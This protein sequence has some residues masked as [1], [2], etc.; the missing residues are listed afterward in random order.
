MDGLVVVDKPSG[1]S[2]HTAVQRMRRMANTRRIGHLGTL[3]PLASGVLPLV[4]GRATRL[5]KFFLG[6]ERSYE[7]TVRCGFS[8]TTYDR[9]GDPT[10]P[11][12]SVSLLARGLEEILHSFRG[13][14]SQCPPPF[15]AKKVGGERAYKLARANQP[16]QLQP[17]QV[18]IH[19][20]DLIDVA[21]DTFTV[22]IRC[23]SG[24]Y[25]R[26]LAHDIGQLLGCGAHVDSLRRIT[27]GELSIAD[28]R[29]LEELDYLAGRDRLEEALVEAAHLLPEFP[30]LRVDEA[31]AIRI[32][33]G[34]D[35]QVSRF[36]PGAAAERIKA[37]GPDGR[38]LAIGELRLPG[39]Y[40]PAIVL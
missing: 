13:V 7:A 35:F 6:H 17:V 33:H 27:V 21:V 12:V 34:R 10:S 14:V 26:S 1:I 20:L 22:R 5:A 37:I 19:E 23:S 38:L 39:S 24:V 31:A 18:A 4:I 32:G 40:H 28:S 8:T 29:T 30:A 25:V 2:S 16:V 15:S 36:S 9:D 3:D 11:L